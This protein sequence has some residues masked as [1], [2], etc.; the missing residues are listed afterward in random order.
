[1]RSSV[2]LH[3]ENQQVLLCVLCHIYIE[4][5]SSVACGVMEMLRIFVVEQMDMIL[6]GIM[7][8]ALEH[9]VEKL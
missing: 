9:C 6:H 2:S 7:Q 3:K 4:R 1:M 8:S 5:E